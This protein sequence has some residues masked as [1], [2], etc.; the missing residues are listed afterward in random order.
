MR[1]R[2]RLAIGA[3]AVLA[4]CASMARG[5]WAQEHVVNGGFEVPSVP[6]GT[7]GQFGSIPGWNLC[8]GPSIEIQN[9]CCGDPFQGEQLVE[10]DS[11]GSSAICQTIATIPGRQYR[12]TFAYSPRPTVQD[13]RINVSWN[14]QMLTQLDADGTNLSNTDWKVFQFSVTAS[15]PSTV[16][17]FADASVSDGVGGYIDAV[18]VL[19]PTLAPTM[20][21]TG[22]GIV[23][24]ALLGVGF[25]RLQRS[26]AR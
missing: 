22:I 2:D 3:V 20:G 12:L 9:H 6:F 21:G 4:L 24:L 23:A 19:P 26:A 11:T 18:S 15:G 7:D 16:L 17:E 14:G 1:R 13:N 10:L 5:S 25:A 8:S